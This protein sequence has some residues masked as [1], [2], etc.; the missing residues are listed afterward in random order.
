M[1]K[2]TNAAIREEIKRMEIQVAKAKFSVNLHKLNLLVAEN[3][4]LFDKAGEYSLIEWER[5][6][7]RIL[8]VI[9]EAQEVAG[10]G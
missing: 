6:L 10:N 3:P 7:S 5:N 9:K 1:T 8:S 4:N 2:E